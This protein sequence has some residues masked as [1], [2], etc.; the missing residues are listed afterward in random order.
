MDFFRFFDIHWF[1]T[2]PLHNCWNLWLRI[3]EICIEIEINSPLS[4]MREVG[5][6][7]Y[8]WFG[9]SSSEIFPRKLSAKLIRRVAY[10]MLGLFGESVDPLV[11][12]SLFMELSFKRHFGK[13]KP[14]MYLRSRK[15]Y[16]KK[17]RVKYDNVGDT[18]Y[19]LDRGSQ[20]QLRISPKIKIR[21]EKVTTFV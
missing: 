10:C 11:N 16:Y 3:T 5:D 15:V 20:F 18:L 19:I 12:W 14:G 4:T 9:E 21:N 13:N 1:G 17:Q 6:S 8:Y 2:G 7:A